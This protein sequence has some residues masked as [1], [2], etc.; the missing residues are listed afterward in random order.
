MRTAESSATWK[1]RCAAKRDYL[2]WTAAVGKVV[3][4]P[5]ADLQRAGSS[6]PPP[7]ALR[8]S[9][10]SKT[11]FLSRSRSSGAPKENLKPAPA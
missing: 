2:E 6:S 5:P 9:S 4:L 7:R 3:A 10:S 11:S 1:F 8:G